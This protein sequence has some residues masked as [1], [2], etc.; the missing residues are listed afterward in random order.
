MEKGSLVLNE[1]GGTL[2]GLRE[3]LGADVV[4][5]FEE[6]QRGE[7]AAELD[8]RGGARRGPRGGRRRDALLLINAVAV[9]EAKE[10]LQQA[11]VGVGQRAQTRAHRFAPKRCILVSHFWKAKRL[12]YTIYLIRWIVLFSS[13]SRTE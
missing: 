4:Q 11:D 1:S 8:E 2:I 5:S 13:F 7:D 12:I 3:P 6:Y 10:V 9:Q